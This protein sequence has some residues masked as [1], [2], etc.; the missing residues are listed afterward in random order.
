[1]AVHSRADGVEHP[2]YGQ[3]DPLIAVG[4]LGPVA[5]GIPEPVGFLVVD[6]PGHAAGDVE[7]VGP[8]ADLSQGI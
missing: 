5:P 6:E 2:A 3:S 8:E 4:A 1:M 7:V